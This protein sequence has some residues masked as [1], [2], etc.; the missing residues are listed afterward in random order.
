MFGTGTWAGQET[1][2][3]SV[4]LW[5]G[6]LAE[7]IAPFG[8]MLG[9]TFN[10]IFESQLENLQNADRFYYLERLDG[11]NFLSQLEGNSFAE[12][13]GRNSTADGLPAVA[14]FRP[15]CVFNMEF[16]ANA[17]PV[18]PLRDGEDDPSD[19]GCDEGEMARFPHPDLD[20]PNERLV[21]FARRHDPLSRWPARDLE[22]LRHPG[23][24]GNGGRHRMR[25]DPIESCPV[26]VTTRSTATAVTTAS[27]PAPA[28]TT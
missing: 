11:L 28:T 21:K 18:A 2:L 23:R 3:N 27:R 14:F 1:G 24:P 16:L 13:I 22:R 9:S 17:T 12:L 8:G 4:D 5:V 25:P 26:R 19:D 15:D 10:F 6:G 20:T 7:K